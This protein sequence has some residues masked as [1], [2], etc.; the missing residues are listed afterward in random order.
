MNRRAFLQGLL[1]SA[2]APA[3]PPIPAPQGAAYLV[4]EDIPLE[5]FADVTWA[6]IERLTVPVGVTHVRLSGQWQNA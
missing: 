5:R 6:Q 3:L 4:F 1:A 2:A